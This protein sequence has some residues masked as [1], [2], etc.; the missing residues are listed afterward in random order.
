[1][2]GVDFFIAAMEFLMTYGWAITVVVI[3]ISALAYFGVLDPSKFLA[4]N[5]CTLPTG[6]S[7][8]DSRVYVQGAFNRLE[9]NLKNN[10]GAA[11]SIDSID[12]AQFNNKHSPQTISMN[13]GEQTKTP[14][15][16]N[17]IVVTDLTNIGGIPPGS[18]MPSGTKYSFDYTLTYTNTDTGLPHTV[19]GHVQGKVN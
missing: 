16:P 11:I 14:A 4:P 13:N 9:I 3:A 7:C 1:M 19:R 18:L 10:L 17:N 2:G 8:M 15:V 6:L 5:Q 12:I